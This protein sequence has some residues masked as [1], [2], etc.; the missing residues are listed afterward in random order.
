MRSSFFRVLLTLTR[1]PVSLAVTFTAVTALVLAADKP[2]WNHLLPILGIFLLASGASAFNQY[3]EWPYDEQMERTRSRPVPSRRIS[4]AEALR[5]ATICITGGSLLL[6]YYAPA[7]CFVLGLVNI[8]WYNG[9]YTW[10]KRKTAF[11]VVPGALTG[12]IPVLMGWIAGGGNWNDPTAVFLALFIFLWQMP[13]FW[14]LMLKYGDE[15]RKAGF[16]VITDR[17]RESTVRAV[18]M[19]WMIASSAASFMMIYF[20]IVALHP[21][22]YVLVA[23]NIALLLVLFWQLFL[24]RRLQFRL[25][26]ISANLFMTVVM[27]ALIIDRFLH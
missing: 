5:I 19:A 17:I 18:I 26:F 12:S 15:Y 13:H 27:V 16:P 10:L 7:L 23:F 24:T 11:A 21:L 25:I 6:L 9:L 1:F 22:G 14:M 3:Q 2:G 20:G 4:T 8:V